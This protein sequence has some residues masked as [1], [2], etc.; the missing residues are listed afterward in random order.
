M[1]EVLRYCSLVPE[2]G[3]LSICICL[4]MHVHHHSYLCFFLL[5]DVTFEWNLGERACLSVSK[6]RLGVT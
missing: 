4:Y 6:D 1:V 2:R 3:I 5:L